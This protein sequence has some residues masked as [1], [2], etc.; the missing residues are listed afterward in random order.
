MALS[1]QDFLR[2]VIEGL[3]ETIGPR[4][5]RANANGAKPKE[6]EFESEAPPSPISDQ[7]IAESNE[8]V[9]LADFHAYM[10]QHT[11][12]FAPTREMW[13]AGSVNA[14][15]APIP[16]TDGGK[17][18]LL[19]PS[20]WLDCN[21]PVEQMT[22]APGLPMLIRDK[23]ISEGGWIERPPT[24]ELGDGSQADPW[25]EHVRR[26]YPNDADH[27]IKY[28]AQRV[29]RPQD[30]INHVLVLGG[31]QGIGKDTLLEPVRRAVGAW[32]FCEVSPAQ[33]MGRFTG[34]LKSVILRV[35]EARDLGDTDRYS[36]YDHLKAFA[37]A[38]PDTLRVDEKYV[39]EHHVLNCVGVVLTSNY[40]T[41]GI[42]LP[43]DDRRHYVAWS[44]LSKENFE[45]E[46]WT[47]LWG[48]YDHDGDRHVAAYLAKLDLSDFD[49]KAPPPKTEAF[50]AIVDSN[51]APED[52]ELADVLD[53]MGNPSATTLSEIIKNT[54]NAGLQEWLAD[55]K[56]RRL[57][58]H[59]LEQCGY[60]QARNDATKDG[61]WV[62]NRKR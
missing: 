50:W 45:T 48:W 42:Y 7:P 54:D 3:E 40:K 53:A 38:P 1:N 14:R 57:I 21:Q 26:V 58:P 9:A 44:E 31:N 16:V 52:A 49:A 25:I 37:A 11:Y 29:Q 30:K 55:R 46:Y 61:L 6:A 2:S 27:I 51:R 47:Q 22:W 34:F 13:A 35:S 4:K 33:M 18:K 39:R 56:S 10:P 59:R 36:F 12:I 32:N 17:S 8:G 24:I 15:I 41:G 19:P 23:L 5:Q 20:A 62:I 28:L 43:A 60:V